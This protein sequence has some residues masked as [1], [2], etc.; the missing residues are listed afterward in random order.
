MG[1][2]IGTAISDTIRDVF[3][4]TNKKLGRLREGQ[5]PAARVR[6]NIVYDSRLPCPTFLGLF[7]NP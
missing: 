6:R 5:V 3:E 1:L 2:T 7:E 4:D